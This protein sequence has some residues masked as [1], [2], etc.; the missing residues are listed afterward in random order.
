MVFT[1]SRKAVAAALVVGVIVGGG[2]TFVAPAVASQD[3][4]YAATNW[5]KIWK[6][7]LQKYA[8]KRY[9]TKKQSNAKYSTKTE[10]STLLGNYYTKAQSDANYYT[11]AQSDAAYAAK[12]S[13]YT[14][15]ESDAKYAPYPKTMRGT[16]L[17]SDTVSGASVFSYDS[18]SFSFTL[19]T[20]PSVVFMPA[21]GAAN[22]NCTGSA[23]APQAAAGFL[24]I[25]ESVATNATDF[26]FADA[27]GSIGSASP[28]GLLIRITS[29]GAGLSRS[30]GG[31][32]VTPAATG[33]ATTVKPSGAVT[34]DFFGE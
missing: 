16:Y 14:K 34:G 3:A 17:V 29:G 27:G 10:T 22:A 33:V 7:K 1:G 5:K 18:L 6:K 25:Y 12:G 2:M 9:Y 26:T 15:A 23:T 8:D 13:S 24:C 4:S 21:G 30:M 28:Y 19:A 32:A 31:W 20:A 11:K